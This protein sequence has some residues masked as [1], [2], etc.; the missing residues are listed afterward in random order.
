MYQSPQLATTLDDVISRLEAI[1]ASSKQSN[2]RLGYFAA[3]YHKVTVKVKEGIDGGQF[4]NGASLAKLDITFANRYF[5][6]LDK[7][8]RGEPVSKSWQVAF[9]NG[10]KPSVLVL[11]HLLLGMNTH[12][13]L[14]LGIATVE[15]ANGNIRSL[16]ADFDSINTILSSLTYGVI[17]KLNIVSPMLSLLGFS[18]TKSNSMLIQFSMGNARDG[19]WCF[20]E[21]LSLK[22]DSAEYNAFITRRDAEIAEL[23][24]TLTQSSGVLKFGIFLIHLFEWKNVKAI[25]EVLSDY[26]K[27]FK[28]DMIP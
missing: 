5:D 18:G 16:K 17:S 25:I 19:S 9:D 2:N 11:Q 23:G 22:T 6:A 8:T 26:K 13:N 27:P 3:L 20:A 10:K 12:I 14:D 4:S 28:K 24:E 21:D 15:V 1:I 7:W